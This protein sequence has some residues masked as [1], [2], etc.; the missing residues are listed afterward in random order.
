M[1]AGFVTVSTGPVWHFTTDHTLENTG[2][3]EI[4]SRYPAYCSQGGRADLHRS[5][6]G[7]A[8]G[9]GSSYETWDGIASGCAYLS[10]RWPYISHRNHQMEGHNRYPAD[11]S[12]SNEGR[13]VQSVRN[14]G[15]G[16]ERKLDRNPW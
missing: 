13:N 8:N 2:R 11:S 5:Q 16:D 12:R 14:Q 9:K 15:P 6:A 10:H 3:L 1:A 4:T 7:H